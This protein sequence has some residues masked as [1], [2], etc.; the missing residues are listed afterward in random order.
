MY[1]QKKLLQTKFHL[2]FILTSPTI[3]QSHSLKLDLKSIPKNNSWF[4]N[5]NNFGIENNRLD[6][7]LFFLK[8]LCLKLIQKFTIFECKC[9]GEAKK[10]PMQNV[11]RCK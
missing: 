10:M 5:T 3:C 4:L 2:F 6:A 7:E 8:I 9:Q 11:G 1:N